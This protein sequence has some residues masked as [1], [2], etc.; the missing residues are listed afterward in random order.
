[1]QSLLTILMGLVEGATEFLPISSTGHLILT[2]ALTGFQESVGEEFAN[3]FLVVI[4]SGAILAVIA[5]YPGRF[6]E[7]VDVRRRDGFAGIRGI[8]LL[9]VTTLPAIVVGLTA[10]SYIKEHLLKPSVVAVGFT[11]GA[12]WILGVEWWRPQ[13]RKTGLDSLNWKDSL[14]VGLFQ[15]LAILCP[16][17]SRSAS[18][19]LG[20]MTWG[21][22]RKTATEYS[23]FA[24]VPALLAAGA[25]DLYKNRSHFSAA[26]VWLLALGTVVSFLV[27]WAAVKLF[28]RYLTRHTFTPFAWY[29]LAVAAA[30]VYFSGP[31]KEYFS[32]P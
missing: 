6:R 2:D 10:G 32:A 22:D 18:T 14:I 29:R 25:H 16:G 24:A 19:I 27:A 11:V 4:Q 20:G 8:M 21:I 30:I 17:M 3:T 13:A 9:A 26:Q 23:F 15:C 31:L 7:L 5:A 12:L 1:M 28:V